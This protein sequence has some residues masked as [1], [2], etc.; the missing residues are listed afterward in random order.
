[1]FNKKNLNMLISVFILPL[2]FITLADDT[3]DLDKASYAIGVQSATLL[4]DNIK[5]SASVGIEI[6]KETLKKGFLDALNGNATMTYDEAIPHLQALD[7]AMRAKE[8]SFY[9]QIIME[10]RAAGKAFMEQQA[11]LAN[12][13]TTESGIQYKVLK[14][15]SGKSPTATQAVTVHYKGM[16]I[17]GNKFDSSYDRGQP[18]TFP[19]NGVIK[20]WTEA[21]QLMKEGAMYE[22]TIPADLAYGDDV[23]NPNIPPGST[24]VFLVELLEV[25]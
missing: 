20:G 8:N 24:L 22:L 7:G 3:I 9:T 12:V 4:S 1:M 23:N 25:K 6:N 2:S 19:L 18:A 15:G 14:E 21:L 16:L 13:Q 10:N 5:R 17:D 11:Q